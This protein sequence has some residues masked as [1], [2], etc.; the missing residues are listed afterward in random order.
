MI[1]VPPDIFNASQIIHPKV[2]ILIETLLYSA[3]LFS[4]SSP[5]FHARTGFVRSFFLSF[6]PKLERC[7]RL[8]P[9]LSTLQ[10]RSP[11]FAFSVLPP[12]PLG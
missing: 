12:S 6:M 8:T 3:V 2:L 5:C 4:I 11:F 7:D 9:P 1:S 10:V